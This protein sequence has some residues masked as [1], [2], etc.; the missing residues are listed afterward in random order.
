MMNNIVIESDYQLAE[1]M[2]GMLHE[3]ELESVACIADYYTIRD[4]F[5]FLILASDGE[6]EIN[7]IDLHEDMDEEYML[8][9][10]KLGIWIYYMRVN[11]RYAKYDDEVVFIR[12]GCS[13]EVLK[14]N[15]RDDNHILIFTYED[16]L[17]EEFVCNK[18]CCDC[19]NCEEEI[20]EET[21]DDMYGF[22]FSMSDSRGT[23]NYSFYST[24]K[25]MVEKMRVEMSE[26][27]K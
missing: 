18:D 13:P 9:V 16:E 6:L 4:L 27:L 5:G 10:D 21:E 17:E 26:R 12:N 25:N 11:D 3:L 7:E 15:L 1:T 23:T 22:Q 20:E 8:I 19:M 24:D 2:L 14:A